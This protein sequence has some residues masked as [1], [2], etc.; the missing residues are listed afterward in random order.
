MCITQSTERRVALHKRFS[1]L[2]SVASKK[3]PVPP[4][5]NQY[6]PILIQYHHVSTI[7]IIY[8]PVPLHTYPVP[9]SINQYWPI[10]AQYHH[11]TTSTGFYWPSTTKHQPLPSSTDLV[12]SYIN[13]SR[14]ILTQYHQVSTSTNLYCCCLAITD[15]CTVYPGSCFCSPHSHLHTTWLS[16][17]PRPMLFNVDPEVLKN[18][19]YLYMIDSV[20]VCWSQSFD[21]YFLPVYDR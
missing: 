3:Y 13:Q 2:V 1:L 11:I 15:F 9:P 19:F 18:I 20:F 8:Q 12:P 17:P 4:R 5:I 7:T 14:S 16:L 21:K 6:R 10:L